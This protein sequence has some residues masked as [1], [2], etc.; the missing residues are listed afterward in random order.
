MQPP[1]VVHDPR[2]HDPGARVHHGHRQH[3]RHVLRQ[4]PDLLHRLEDRVRI[5]NNNK[6]YYR[7]FNPESEIVGASLFVAS[8]GGEGVNWGNVRGMTLA[9]GKLIY[10]LTDGR[11]YS[12]N[13]GGTK[14]TGAVTQI[15]SAT[16]WQSRGLFVFNQ[17]TDTFAPSKP[18]KP[19]GTSSTFDSIDLSWAASTDNFG[20]PL[21][22]RVYRDGVQIDQVTSSS[23]STV[24]YTDTGLAGRE[25]AHVHRRC[26]G[27]GHQRERAERRLR[28]R[29]R[30]SHR[31]PRH[32]AIRACLP[33]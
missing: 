33:A 22:Y 31:T 28:P 6:L 4:R 18:G 23:T 13:W 12:V 8:T 11:L 30:C 1:S 21:T 29:S 7:Y 17:V 19:S 10:A 16:T 14:P 2:N 15:S 9:S 26:G 25:H 5:A 32:R 3:D 24:T 27:R 20:G